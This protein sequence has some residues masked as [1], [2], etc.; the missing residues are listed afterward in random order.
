MT[1]RENA[2]ALGPGET[3]RASYRNPA[4]R[5][6]PHKKYSFV[7]LPRTLPALGKEK[8]PAASAAVA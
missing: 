4:L 5:S 7:W 8:E 2:E 3:Y 1:N 6:K